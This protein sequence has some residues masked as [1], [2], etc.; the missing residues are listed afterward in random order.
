MQ[1]QQL[2]KNLFS[3]S[4]G[5]SHAKCT[6]SASV[7]DQKGIRQVSKIIEPK[8]SI[9]L[10]EKFI[11]EPNIYSIHGDEYDCRGPGIYRFY[12]LPD[13]YEQR[14]VFPSQV[15]EVLGFIGYLWVYGR[16]RDIPR[17]DNF[18]LFKEKIPF[19]DC[20]QLTLVAEM[21]FQKMGVQ[22]RLVMGKH[23]GRWSGIDDSHCLIEFRQKCGW[24]LYDPSFNCCF[25]S[26]GRPANLQDVIAGFKNGS[27]EILRLPGN[28]SCG[29]WLF[30]GHDM[31]FWV[32]ERVMSESILI[33]WYK[34][35]LQ[36]P[37]IQSKKDKQYFFDSGIINAQYIKQFKKNFEG[38]SS[39]QFNKRFYS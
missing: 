29:P 25:N 37:V 2:I 1:I 35:V 9:P 19:L 8:E 26:H 20:Y 13:Y 34:R 21:V 36:V 4:K 23:A 12:R 10:P 5:A 18:D 39:E 31:S 38:L 16:T 32:A 30:D 6:L 22:C 3:S 15:N 28:K 14:L 24:Y 11:I 17:L 7:I 33:N 27:I